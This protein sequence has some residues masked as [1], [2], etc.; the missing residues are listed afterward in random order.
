VATLSILELRV[1]ILDLCGLGDDVATL[2]ASLP[3]W[4]HYRGARVS[5]DSRRLSMASSLLLSLCCLSL[6]CLYEEFLITLYQFGHLALFIK[7]DRS[8]FQGSMKAN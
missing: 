2:V 3:P 4:G 8:L 5:L 1:K 6:I 7:R